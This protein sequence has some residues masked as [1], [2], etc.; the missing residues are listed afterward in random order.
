[1]MI[2]LLIA[3]VSAS[4][5]VFNAGLF[6]LFSINTSIIEHLNTPSSKVYNKCCTSRAEK[7]AGL[8]CP[9]WNSTENRFACS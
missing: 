4:L 3:T 6:S 8:F 9:D 7:G 1:M 5:K 2:L